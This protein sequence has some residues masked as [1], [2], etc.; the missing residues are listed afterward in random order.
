MA[1][2]KRHIID[3]TYFFL[4]QEVK[5][6]SSSEVYSVIENDAFRRIAEDIDYPKANYSSVLSSGEYIVSSPADF[7][8]IDQNWSPV[9]KDAAGTRDLTPTTSISRATLLSATPGSPQEYTEWNETQFAIHP[10]STSGICVLPYV[11]N[12]S[13][14]SGDS[15]TNELTENCYMAAVYY[16]VQE[17]MMKDNDPRAQYWEGKYNAEIGRLRKRFNEKYEV[18]FDMTPARDYLRENT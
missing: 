16:T 13:M 10:P 1:I 18:G 8:K 5:F 6:F 17:C 3:K 4:R 15:D 12:P 9:F 7:L 2:T 11:K 14:L